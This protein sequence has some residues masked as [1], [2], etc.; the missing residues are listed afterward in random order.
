MM[1]SWIAIYTACFWV[2]VFPFFA[3]SFEVRTLVV[4]GVGAILSL[5]IFVVSMLEELLRK[6]KTDVAPVDQFRLPTSKQP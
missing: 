1:K 2:F 3:S 4:M 6:Q 5:L